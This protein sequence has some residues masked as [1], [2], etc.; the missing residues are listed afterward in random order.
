MK[1]LFVIP[2]LSGG[3]AETQTILLAAE[4]SRRLHDVHLAYWEPGPAA[5]TGII[6]KGHLHRLNANGWTG[7]AARD[8][9][10]LF[11]LQ[12]QL[13]PAVVQTCI[14]PADILGGV[15]ALALRQ[16]WVIREPNGSGFAGRRPKDIVRARIG[17]WADVIVS[18][19]PGGVSLWKRW[20]AA[21]EKLRLVPNAVRVPA[22]G[23]VSA[24]FGEYTAP[25]RTKHRLLI[26]GR[27][28]PEKD[29]FTSTEV[30]AALLT[31]T[32]FCVR[33]DVF[34][35]GP[36][37]WQWENV[38]RDNASRGGRHEIHLHGFRDDWM[39]LVT[40]GVPL[41]STSLHEGRPNVPW[42]A[43][44]RGASL[45]LSDIEAHREI[46]NDQGTDVRLVRPRDSGGF[47]HA[48]LD[49][50]ASPISRQIVRRRW[51]AASKYT[52]PALA[53]AYETIYETI[54]MKHHG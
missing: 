54:V 14:I 35:E 41:L 29:V 27:M 47:I 25:A 34:G 38:R 11:S 36:E 8:F 45:V 43:L 16:P 50:W 5:P 28:V 51:N 21:E 1:I 18:N 32:D 42:E 23:E 46:A 31:R 17:R 48:V 37:L 26:V 24:G 53:A 33:I 19:A 12:K 52:I 49:A 4:L 2:S 13:S 20:G 6:D 30:V 44:G 39:S 15:A 7:I 22:W 3:G 9:A 40:A 10:R